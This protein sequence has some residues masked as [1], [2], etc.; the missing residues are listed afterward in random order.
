MTTDVQLVD[1]P[2]LA[3]DDA[4]HEIAQLRPGGVGD[5]PPPDMLAP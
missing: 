3:D 1:L 2:L 4:L 5:A